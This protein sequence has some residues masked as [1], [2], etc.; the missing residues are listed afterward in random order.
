MK[1]I[2]LSSLLLLFSQCKDDGLARYIDFYN[3][4]DKPICYY[5]PWEDGVFYPDTI[6]PNI[7]PMPYKPFPFNKYSN[8]NFGNP[9]PN[10]NTLFAMFPTDTMSIF[11]FDPD[12][13]AKYEW[14][15]IRQ[16]YKIL[17]RYDL[18]H[19]DLKA[20]DWRIYYPPTEKM[21][22][23]KMYPLYHIR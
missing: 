16:D 13:L 20:L 22:N 21:K 10:E 9:G 2:F 19:N 4:S 7:I 15:T 14:E 17:V 11:F 3:N 18:S 23:M 12:T 5:M 6:L 8:A 1:K